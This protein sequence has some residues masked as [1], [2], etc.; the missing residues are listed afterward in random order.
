MH[1]ENGGR[2]EAGT[3]VVRRIPFS[4]FFLVGKI[5]EEDR[6]S[7]QPQKKKGK[8]KGLIPRRDSPRFEFVDGSF[9]NRVN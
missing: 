8:K 1:C 2:G 9:V 4:F 6:F 5:D 7:S 3:P